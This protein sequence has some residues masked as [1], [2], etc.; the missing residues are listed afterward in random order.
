MDELRQMLLDLGHQLNETI[1]AA[2]RA[3]YLARRLGLFQVDEQMENTLLLWLERFADTSPE[4][5]QAGSI[6]HLLTLVKDE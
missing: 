1:E 5:V 3:G 6:G 2:H 4:A